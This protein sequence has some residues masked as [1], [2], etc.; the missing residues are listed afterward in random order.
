MNNNDIKNIWKSGVDADINPYSESELNDIVVK[1]ARKS[2]K[3]IQPGGILRVVVVASIIYFIII[4]TAGDSTWE[5]RMLYF[6]GLLI[7]S[8]S[9]FLYERAS[10]KMNQYILGSPVKEWLEYRIDQVE[11]SIRFK[12][13]YDF[14]IYG[15][16]ILLGFSFSLISQLLVNSFNIVA[17]IVS[18]VVI[19]VIILIIKYNDNKNYHKTLMGLKEIHQQLEE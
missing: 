7:L 13:K 19:L 16:A 8:G 2:M 9:Y 10:R 1:S 6:I 18:F 15:G 14:L 11:R 3:I 5:M 12:H 17:S 4:I